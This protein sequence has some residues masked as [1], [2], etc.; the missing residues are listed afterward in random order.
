[1]PPRPLPAL[2]VR[3]LIQIARGRGITNELWAEL[4]GMTVPAVEM[5]LC[6]PLT[7]QLADRLAVSLGL[8]PCVVW[9]N[10]WWAIAR[11]YDELYDER[12]QLELCRDALRR[13][14]GNGWRLAESQWL[15]WEELAS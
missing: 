1:M 14:A 10:D 15:Q 2:D 8:H 4:A 7:W 11:A 5:A 9:G 6:R 12:K 13:R 3:P